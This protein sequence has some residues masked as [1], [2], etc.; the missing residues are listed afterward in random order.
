MTKKI[1]LLFVLLLGIFS[2][3]SYAQ[4]DIS[5]T[6]YSTLKDAFDAINAG[7]HT[8]AIVVSI[9]GSTVETASAVLNASGSGAA[10]YTSITISPTGGAARLITGAVTGYLIDLNGADNVTIDG[11]NTGGN[12]LTISNTS[13]GASGCIR[14]IADASNNTITNCTLSGSSSTAANGVVL[15]STG[16]TTGNDN[17]TIS[18]STIGG[19]GGILP[20]ND[21]YSLG[22][23][24]AIDNSGNIISGNN[25]Q[26]YFSASLLSSG[27]FMSTG[28][29]GWTITNNKLFQ[30]T[31][32]TYTTANIH[33]GIAASAG[34]GYT[35]TG[36]TIGY[37]SSAG[38]GTYTMAGTIATRFIGIN[39]AVSTTV[40]T[41]SVQGNTIT[42]ISLATS[43]GAATTNGVIC[44]INV[45]AG[46]VNIG[47]VTPN[48]IGG[49]SGTGLI[50][51]VPTTTQGMI[52]GIN[53]SSTGTILI[54]NNIIGGFT[55]SGI[56][57]AVA[58]GVSG[59]NVSG[60]S[61]SMTIT[62]NTIGNSTAENMRA[63]T[64]ALTTGS[65]IA[66]GINMTSQPTSST[67]TNNTIQ[68]LVSYGTGATSYARGFWTGTTATAPYTITGNTVY[69][70]YTNSTLATYTNGQ[71]GAGGIILGGGSG[72]VIS[73][74]TVYNIGNTNTGTGGYTVG[75][76]VSAN[77][78][79]T[80]ITKNIVYGLSNASTSTTATAPGVAGGI[81]I[82]SGNASDTI[83]NNMVTLGVGQTTNTAFLGIMLNH[84]STPDPVSNIFYNTIHIEGTVT[85]GAQPSFG[86]ARTDFSATART[87]GVIIFNNV[88]DNSRTGGTGK[89][90]A[91][92]NNY[93]AVTSSATGWSGTA[94]NYNVLNSASASS[95]GYWT[96]DQTLAGWR[97]AS[98]GDANSLS[99]I[100][101]T[102]TNLSSGNLRY[103]MGLTA[104]L[105]ES[106]A[107]TITTVTTD[108]DGF[109]RPKPGAVNGGGIAPDFGAGESDMVPIDISGPNILYTNITNTASTS[110]RT[111][112]G[113]ATITDLTGVNVTPGTNPR[114]YYKKSTD[115]NT[116]GGNTSGDNGWKW[117][118]A[119]NASSPFDFTIDNSI[120]F[121]GSVTGGDIIQYFVVAQDIVLPTP[122][123]SSN[124]STG[125]TGTG[126]GSITSAPTTP[127]F[128][129]II[130]APLSGTYTVGL[131]LFNKLSGLNLYTEE[132]T[133]KV[134]Q[135]VP[136]TEDNSVVQKS[137][138]PEPT[139]ASLN[140]P[141]KGTQR[142]TV[143]EKYSVLMLNG[144]EYAGAKYYSITQADRTQYGLSSD[145]VGVYTTITAALT[146]LNLRG[147]TGNTTF[148]L[149]DA[150]YPTETYPLSFNISGGAPTPSASATV[151]LKPALGV[152]PT[153]SGTLNS[154][155]LIK[156]LNNYVIIDGSN[157]VGGT[158]K[159]MT[160]TNISATGPSVIH[161]ASTGTTYLDNVTLKNCNIIN[162]L[163]TSTAVVVSD[164]TLG[165]AGY[166]SNITIQNNSIQKAYIGM[167]IIGNPL[168]TSF[169]SV[170]GN[171]LITSGANSIR[172]TGLYMQQLNGALVSQNVF[173]NF[174]GTS[175]EDDNGIWFATGMSNSI[176]ERNY[177]GTLKYTGTGGYGCHGIQV[178]TGVTGANITVRNNQFCDLSGDGWVNTTLGDNTHGIYAFSTQTG[179]KLYNNSINFNGNTL[180][181]T[182]AMSYG[183]TLGTGTTADIRNNN[184]VN[185]LGLLGA[186]GL[187]T[188]CIF[189]QSGVSQLEAEDNNNYYCNASGSGIKGVAYVVSTNYT[190]VAAYAAVTL[191]DAHSVSGDPA[192]LSATS[193]DVDATNVN[194][195]V[196]N[197]TG[198]NG[199]V[200]D[201]YLGNP[202]PT[203][204][205]G[206]CD[207]GAFNVIPSVS[208]PNAT[209]TGTIGLGNT[210]TYSIFGR[211]FASITWGPA[212]TLPGT[213]TAVYNSGQTPP[214]PPG[215]ALYGYGTWSLTPDVQPSGGATYDITIYFDDSQTGT[216]NSPSTNLI[217]AKYDGVSWTDYQPG[218]GAGQSNLNYA[219]KS[220]TVL[221]LGSFSTFALTDKDNPLPVELSSFSSV[222]DRR[223]VD[224]KW[225]TVSEQNNSGFDIERKLSS[226]QTW[227]KVGRVT[228]NGT[229]N[230]AH[231]YSFTDLNLQTGNY[232]YRLKQIDFNG[233]Y[234]YYNLANEV[235]VGVPSKFDLS[236]NYPNPF[237]PTTKINYDLPFDSKVSIK[238]FD[239]TG[240]EVALIVNAAQSAGYYTVQFNGSNLASG[241][242]FYNIIAE[243]GNASKF[244]STKKMVLV[245]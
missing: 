67:I 56:T 197:G 44:G 57:A 65:S 161:F 234:N 103:N 60:V 196:V 11:L 9:N 226:S 140:A 220:I 55:S 181:Q 176:A 233:N 219:G 164:A 206:V 91:I 26:D 175:A 185:N 96:G 107:T 127:N 148:S 24:A 119:S 27:I 104:T 49:S 172:F 235:N 124:P 200:T 179:L 218:T 215:S 98:A 73:G 232:N 210:T 111:L 54:Q 48:T 113:F 37:S 76:I 29:S 117:V 160:I 21:I 177:V 239:M 97:T 158:T 123:V 39:L 52:V 74:N 94:S 112:T 122:Y 217:L 53:S 227:T 211:T 106:G 58:G 120:I 77:G 138:G 90:Y 223:N 126:V 8:G 194:C 173:Q 168:S 110:N 87:A 81:I 51:A 167:Y 159:D 72:S 41:S 224:L 225:T 63:G 14:Y 50:T 16:T 100:S 129:Y 198:V 238:L 174:D 23:S 130:G 66:S 193:G 78:V 156:V 229:S 145:L 195:W 212:G 189:L 31:T 152:S 135:E 183:I 146:D 114:V 157:T 62:G 61:A 121:G 7:T 154:A 191:K 147:V 80:K 64:T 216:I 68:N 205:N 89:H 222:V 136:I 153:I 209:Q 28:T 2:L 128:Y 32:C 169:A 71:V 43:S 166:F 182:G 137:T 1:T 118:Q 244:V 83:S 186:T 188:T 88:F 155:G 17:N 6:P 132:R 207:I 115:A 47:N 230:T 95:V 45:T 243:G 163:N 221:G 46:N 141:S 245:K 35:I 101:I 192:Y 116:F 149:T 36:N 134:V 84:G 86:L 18:N 228:G 133:R 20:V 108:I 92:A 70:I 190:S 42:A 79:S 59:I 236:Q 34:S 109:A 184:I 125:F 19:A 105:L 143:D 13:N 178:S 3:K 131:A 12:T 75:G 199:L 82:R 237:N 240:K 10:S 208:A 204:S 214:N 151:T 142:V 69:N 5:G 202:R 162:G 242:Y 150:S 170:I 171:S 25:I 187:G 144:S 30:T 213:L 139:S 165:T 4:V 38:T 180:N 231:N 93:G 241:I 102:Y 201:D 15:F 33:N 99:G 203:T 40:A 22:T 85:S